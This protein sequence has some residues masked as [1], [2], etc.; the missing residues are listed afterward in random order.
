MYSDRSIAVVS[1]PIPTAAHCCFMICCTGIS[2]ASFEP[3]VVEARKLMWIGLPSGPRRMPSE[4]RF[5]YPASS[6]AWLARSTSYSRYCVAA[7]SL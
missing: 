5:L 4:L 6:R 1:M 7:F 3:P 2:S